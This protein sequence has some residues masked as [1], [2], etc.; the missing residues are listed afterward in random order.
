M[1][2]ELPMR[3]GN[4]CPSSLRYSEIM[5]FELPMRDGNINEKDI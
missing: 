5:V 1:V 4:I 2:F 3:D